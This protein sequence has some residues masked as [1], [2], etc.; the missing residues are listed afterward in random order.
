MLIIKLVSPVEIP[1]E[2]HV[3]KGINDKTEENE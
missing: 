3:T 2:E 1:M